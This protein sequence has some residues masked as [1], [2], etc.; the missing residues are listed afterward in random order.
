MRAMQVQEP[1]SATIDEKTGEVTWFADTSGQYMLNRPGQILTFTAN[2]AVK[3]KFARGIAATREEL[4]RV[5]G[6]NEPIWA[7]EEAAAFIDKNM[8]DNDRTE[9]RW[10][11][12]AREFDLYY[13]YAQQAQDKTD[14][15]KF[16]GHALRAL[17]ELRQ[18]V[19]SNPNFAL[20]YGTN[21]EWFRVREDA[22]K[23]LLRGDR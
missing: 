19:S 18:M 1:L 8:R 9:K 16:A 12:V 7:G 13:G 23:A 5:M 2:D 17:R 11:V 20:M 10:Q 6:I 14:R 21:D 3:F 22:L 4:A 15:G